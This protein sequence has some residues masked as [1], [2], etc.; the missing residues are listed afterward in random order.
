[1]SIAV[2]NIESKIEK[3]YD[4][5]F[6]ENGILKEEYTQD[7]QEFNRELKETPLHR[8]YLDAKRISIKIKYGL[9]DPFN[10]DSKKSRYPEHYSLE[11]YDTILSLH[12]NSYS[13]K[14]LRIGSDRWNLISAFCKALANNTK[15]KKL[16]LSSLS[17]CYSHYELPAFA[18]CSLSYALSKNNTLRYLDISSMRMGPEKIRLLTKGLCVNRSIKRLNLS[19]N[20][21]NPKALAYLT[22]AL[23][24]MALTFLDLSH[25]DLICQTP[26]ELDHIK[27]FAD[28]LSKDKTL[29]ELKLN[30]S[31]FSNEA[32]TLIVD[33]LSHNTTL[34]HF[35]IRHIQS[36]N[37]ES[38]AI[39]ELLMR[40]HSLVSL[41]CTS[42]NFTQQDL[43]FISEGLAKNKKLLSL[44]LSY[45]DPLTPSKIFI[46]ALATNNTLKFLDLSKCNINVQAAKIIAEAIK[47][48]RGLRELDLSFNR[49]H[50]EVYPLLNEALEENT[51]LEYVSLYNFKT[52]SIKL[53]KK[54][55]IPD[56]IKNL[57]ELCSNP[58]IFSDIY[59]RHDKLQKKAHDEKRD[60]KYTCQKGRKGLLLF[61]KDFLILN[62]VP[63]FE[64]RWSLEP[65][66]LIA[67]YA[68]EPV[69][70]ATNKI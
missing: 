34:K 10:F 14:E 32:I 60:K 24:T 58:N 42:C 48:N 3:D 15:V 33:A 62:P 16:T 25:S 28:Y 2:E 22:M 19:Y 27:T 70:P 55:K 6:Y 68:E 41:D 11:D 8:D 52:T 26:K 69:V 7:V 53:N 45:I 63:K 21:I 47:V 67:D 17:A 9:D 66:K 51:S 57:F 13:N 65:L 61:L 44:S 37:G 35:S 40:N 49:F 38:K 12:N 54:D 39:Q 18:V 50:E 31:K 46:E 56:N 1:M 23:K 43:D 36:N 64:K 5:Y 30:A 4:T 29:I 20:K 59:L